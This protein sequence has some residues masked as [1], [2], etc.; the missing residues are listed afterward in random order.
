MKI[1]KLLIIVA[2]VAVSLL[3]S[4]PTVRAQTGTGDDKLDAFIAKIS[5]VATKLNDKGY[6]VVNITIDKGFQNE[7][8]ETSRTLYAGNEYIILGAGA[9]GISKLGINLLDDQ[10]NIVDK[11]PGSD[12]NPLLLTR[13]DK[14]TKHFF[15]TTIV[16]LDGTADANS[17]YFFGYVVGFKNVKAQ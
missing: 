7:T 10:K 8:Y 17:S 15:E 6:T 14:D 1:T 3:S 2:L 9:D 5:Q 13:P 4:T 12:S 11:A 16:G